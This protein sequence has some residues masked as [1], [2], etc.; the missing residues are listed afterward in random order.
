MDELKRRKKGPTIAGFIPQPATQNSL[1]PFRV[2]LLER[3]INQLVCFS[4]GARG[5]GKGFGL[6]LPGSPD[7]AKADGD[8]GAASPV[9]KD[10]VK[11]FFLFVALC[12]N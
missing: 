10:A 11:N 8:F 6:F 1:S 7:A 9:R 5:I 2:A 12:L 3:L 4:A